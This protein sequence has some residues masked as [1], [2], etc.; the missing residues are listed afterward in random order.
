MGE[1]QNILFEFDTDHGHF[2][3]IDMIYDGRKARVLFSGQQQAAQSGLALDDNPDLLFD[4]NQRLYELATGIR[5]KQ[6]LIIGGGMF[7][8]PA[9]L[10]QDLPDVIIDVVEIDPGLVPVA[11]KHFGLQSDPRLRIIYDDG[12]H[13]L[14]KNQQQYDLIIID[15]YTH[16]LA[17]P[18]LGD[19]TAV[20]FLA[21]SLT[22]QGVVAA[23]VIAA[24]FGRRAEPLRGLINRYDQQFADVALF[25]ASQSL[26][27]WLPQ[28]LVLVAQRN[29][30]TAVDEQIRY[31]RLEPASP[32]DL[33]RDLRHL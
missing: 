8:L 24:Y 9:A 23:N 28:N 16:D 19:E 20:E 1:P 22:A 2:Q 27:L 17:D 10:I 5:P 12:R 15:A 30:A 25:P 14:E 31:R 33:H 29:P 32:F 4:Y 6:M 13:F 26:S 21:R 3:V 18:S 7:T 11:K